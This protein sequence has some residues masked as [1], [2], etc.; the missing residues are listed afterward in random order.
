MSTDS[1]LGGMS[2]RRL[3]VIQEDIIET[4]DLSRKLLGTKDIRAEYRQLKDD[5]KVKYVLY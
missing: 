4:V 1:I 2:A 3:T 5:E